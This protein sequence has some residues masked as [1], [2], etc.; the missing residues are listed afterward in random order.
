[1]GW[2]HPYD[3]EHMKTAEDSLEDFD[4]G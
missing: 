2:I 1:M 4:K 3:P